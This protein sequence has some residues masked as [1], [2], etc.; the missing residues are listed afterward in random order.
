M[1]V[2]NPFRVDDSFVPPMNNGEDMTALHFMETG[3]S[4]TD[5]TLTLHNGFNNRRI[6]IDNL[7]YSEYNRRGLK[8]GEII[9]TLIS[10]ILRNPNEKFSSETIPLLKQIKEINNE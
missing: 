8:L 4:I 6:I 9:D 7:L 3:E 10:D 1:K 2:P 5:H